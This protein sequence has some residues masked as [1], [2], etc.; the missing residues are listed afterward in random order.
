MN[1]SEME[2]REEGMRLYHAGDFFEAHEVWEEIW[3]QKGG[4]TAEFYKGLIQA[5]VALA[6]LKN[7]NQKGARK[8]AERAAGRLKPFAPAHLDL[9]IQKILNDIVGLL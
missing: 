2:L 6:H 3:Q 8:L 7:G 1:L 9:D 5:A 4:S